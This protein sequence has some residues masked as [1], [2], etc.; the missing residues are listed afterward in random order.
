MP[1]PGWSQTHHIFSSAPKTCS[2]NVQPQERRCA[3]AAFCE[4]PKKKTE[5]S[6]YCCSTAK[7]TDDR[8][9]FTNYTD[10]YSLSLF[11]I[12]AASTFVWFLFG[13]GRTRQKLIINETAIDG[14]HSGLGKWRISYSKLNR[15]E[16]I[17]RL[18]TMLWTKMATY[19]VLNFGVFE[20]TTSNII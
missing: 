20:M 7:E 6:G 3:F 15:K 10:N 9:S 13:Q 5:T 2:Y 19:C 14:L 16:L 17:A 12:M 4:Y 1:P 11:V 8:R 18:K